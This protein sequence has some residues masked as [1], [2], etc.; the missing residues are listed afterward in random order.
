[1]IRRFRA[2]ED[3]PRSPA[4]ALQRAEKVNRGNTKR[5][6][7][8]LQIIGLYGILG[9]LYS[10][11]V[12]L[13]EAPDEFAHMAYAAHLAQGKGLPVLRRGAEGPWKQEGVQPPLYYGVLAGIA[14]LSGASLEDLPALYRP[15]PMAS[16]DPQREA[17][18][19]HAFHR[20][21]EI[22][23]RNRTV[24][25][26]RIWRMTSVALGA[27]TIWAAW[28]MARLWFSSSALADRVALWIAT[29]PGFLF[30]SSSI[31]NDNMVNTIAAVGLWWIGKIWR[32]GGSI[33]QA[34]I[35]GVLMGLAALSKASGLLL[36]PIAM[37]ALLL[38]SWNRRSLRTALGLT[39]LALITALS[40]SGSWFYRNIDLYGTPLPLPLLGMNP[41]ALWDI[42]TRL[43]GPLSPWWSDPA[44]TW[45][46]FR[47]TFWGAFGHMGNIRMPDSVYRL[48]DLWAALS[49][50]GLI[51]KAKRFICGERS[52]PMASLSILMLGYVLLIGIGLSFWVSAQGRHSY[53]ALIPLAIGLHQGWEELYR[54]LPSVVRTRLF[55]KLP[56]IGMAMVAILAPMVWILPAYYVP[57]FT[58]AEVQRLRDPLRAYFAD[59]VYLHGYAL[60]DDHV[61][62]GREILL[63]LY[64][65]ALGPAE[66][67]WNLFV[68]LVDAHAPDRILTQEDRYPG[69]GMFHPSQWQQGQR[70]KERIRLRIPAN[71]SPTDRLRVVFGFYERAQWIS[72]NP[73]RWPI[74]DPSGHPLGDHLEIPLS[75]VAFAP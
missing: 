45:E 13:F 49:V 38:A 8:I 4:M 6:G 52:S 50:F 40:L 51:L 69:R 20:P 35:L 68:H 57:S 15:H 74:Y 7:K 47:E 56:A 64:F 61:A 55:L 12:P 34:I 42:R 60:S 36:W 67:E 41:G 10:L 75:Q 48:L 73:Q 66:G 11:V 26:L 22:L 46:L 14:R 30:V 2:D 17:G 18:R 39:G 28:Q 44:K 21:G 9:L 19:N 23:D 16:A 72:G 33:S 29:L 71:L 1:M 53:P 5:P 63:Y 31:N 59:R 32:S 25:V 27:L 58:D 3:I 54:R 70:W 24:V 65:E 62:P 43:Q 37:L